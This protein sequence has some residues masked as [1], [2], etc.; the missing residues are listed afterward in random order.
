[1]GGGRAIGTAIAKWP[2]MAHRSL[3]VTAAACLLSI[4]SAQSGEAPAPG[5]ALPLPHVEH[6]AFRAGEKLTYVLHYGW[7]NA[8]VATLE[9]KHGDRPI[10]GR[11]VLHAV[12]IGQSTGA[13]KAFYKVDD[14]YETFIDKAGVFPWVFIRRVNEGGYIINQDYL[15]MQHRGTVTTQDNKTFKVQPGI[16]DMLSAFYFARTLDFSSAR[17]GDVFVIPC[18]MDGQEWPLRMRYMGKETIKIR[19]GRYRCLKFQPVVQEGRV[20]KS[21]EDLNVWITDDP[22]HVPVLAQAKVL[23]GSIKVEL[24]GYEGLASPIAKE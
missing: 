5:A 4:G 8:G 24:T 17:K 16:Q 18:F 22:N 10:Q 1:M 6:Q 11:E 23:V 13:F 2:A 3:L 15:F 12:G 9:L 20:F 7:L 21:N 19:N 14:R